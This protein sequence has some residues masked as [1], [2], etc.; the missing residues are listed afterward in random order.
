MLNGKVIPD[1]ENNIQRME[2]I[3]TLLLTRLVLKIVYALKKINQ[4]QY[5]SDSKIILAI[6]ERTTG[7]F[8]EYVLT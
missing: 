6:L 3:T 7:Y 8:N 5:I 1:W 2:L 4:I